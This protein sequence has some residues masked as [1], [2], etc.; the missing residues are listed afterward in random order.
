MK[1]IIL[2]VI[3]NEEQRDLVRRVAEEDDRGMSG[4]ARMWL[5]RVAR[6]EVTYTKPTEGEA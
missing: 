2:S 4:W 3:L 1:R 5:L 6:G